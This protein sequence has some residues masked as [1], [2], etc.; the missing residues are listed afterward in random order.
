MDI[1][2]KIFI[3]DDNLE[4]KFFNY[5]NLQ[6]DIKNKKIFNLP[7]ETLTIA[8]FANEKKYQ[9]EFYL[10]IKVD[11]YYEFTTKFKYYDITDPDKIENPI[12]YVRNCDYNVY[13]DPWGYMKV[14]KVIFNNKGFNKFRKK[15][16]LNGY[17][18]YIELIHESPFQNDEEIKNLSCQ[19]K[20]KEKKNL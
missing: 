18:G 19:F 4:L 10:L 3:D 5:F 8:F 20:K 16:N 13:D 12:E 9:E 17:Y 15:I 1:Q 14:D 11:D 2:S 6:D 7:N